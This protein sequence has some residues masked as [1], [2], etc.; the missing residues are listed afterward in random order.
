MQLGRH[1][2]CGEHD[3]HGDGGDYAGSCEKGLSVTADAGNLTAALTDNHSQSV[4][5]FIRIH[6]APRTRL[7]GQ[8]LPRGAG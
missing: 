4:P 7:Q 2:R 5:A 6:P 8:S 3:T 1:A